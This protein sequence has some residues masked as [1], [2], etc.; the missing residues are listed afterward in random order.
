MALRRRHYYENVFGVDQYSM[1][2]LRA[3]HAKYT[4]DYLSFF[5]SLSSMYGASPQKKEIDEAINLVKRVIGTIEG[6]LQ[7]QSIGRDDAKVLYE[8]TGQIEQKKQDLLEQSADVKALRKRLDKIQSETGISTEDL[9]VTRQTVRKSVKQAVQSQKEEAGDFLKRTAPGAMELGRKLAGGAAS[10]L[11]G[12]FGPLLE[13]GY[14]VLKGANSAVEGI[15]KK[16]RERKERKLSSKLKSYTPAENLED[17]GEARGR[18]TSLSGIIGTVTRKARSSELDVEGGNSRSGGSRSRSG[19]SMVEFWSK[20]AYKAKY[21][22][23][24]LGILKDIR[25]GRRGGR[26]GKLTD[27]V[28]N[29]VDTAKD[30]AL[31]GGAML[32]FLGKLGL[33]AAL[34]VAIGWTS[35]Q[36]YDLVSVSA[37]YLKAREAE[38]DASEHYTASVR[39]WNDLIVKE[40]IVPLAKRLGKTEDELAKEQAERERLARRRRQEASPL[41]V[42][43]WEGWKGL[44]RGVDILPNIPEK[45]VE[46]R[47]NEIIRAGGGTASPAARAIEEQTRKIAEMTEA[48]HRATERLDGTS[49]SESGRGVVTG[50]NI[51]DSGD[52]LMNAQSNGQLGFGE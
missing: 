4:R 20:G 22:K 3:L 37:D 11:A 38:K 28:R 35:K 30:F 21:T 23:E 31:L 49:H 1:K 50:P 9:N 46:Q 24:L 51:H 26:R 45:T 6:V 27:L 52:A 40:G 48:I 42:Q 8:L 12:P 29:L 32:P 47:A 36:L 43:A 2:V 34:A 7:N 44:L 16:F 41:H 5:K 25:G 33:Y 19:G 15:R 17:T 10:V 39:Q 14:D 18:G 13:G